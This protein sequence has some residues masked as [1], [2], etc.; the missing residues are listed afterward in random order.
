MDF[1]DLTIREYTDASIKTAM[2]I[3][4]NPTGMFV[5]GKGASKILLK[6][7]LLVEIAEKVSYQQGQEDMREKIVDLIEPREGDVIPEYR[8]IIAEEIKKL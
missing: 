6:K 2:Q 4:H 7:K 3:I 5:T 8:K 1:K